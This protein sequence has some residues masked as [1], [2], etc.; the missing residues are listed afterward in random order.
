MT[1]LP[2]LI[3]DEV[4]PGRMFE[5]QQ[6][7]DPVNWHKLRRG[8]LGFRLGGSEVGSA[9]G[10][11][12]HAT[13]RSLW[14]FMWWQKDGYREING[15]RYPLH[16]NE[17]P[18]LTHG[19]AREES[20]LALHAYLLDLPHASPG[21]YWEA[22]APSLRWPAADDSSYYGCSPD[23]VVDDDALLVECKA[24]YYKAATE[25]QP[26]YLAQVQYQLAVTGRSVCDFVS[27]FYHPRE[28]DDDAPTG[29]RGMLDGVVD[30][31]TDVFVRRIHFNEVYW[32]DWMYPGLRRFTHDYLVPRRQP[33]LLTELRKPRDANGRVIEVFMERPEEFVPN[34][35]WKLTKLKRML[36]PLL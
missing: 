28:N 34:W 6:A 7:D 21:N 10:V 23:S 4:K 22:A 35:E 15:V 2:P 20:V 11:N 3:N 14:E 18:E 24:P 33:P 31:E 17:G 12:S 30:V 1:S 8:P 5:S 19:H 16:E 29:R 26:E 9:L 32:R 36:L 13:P 25:V 27:V